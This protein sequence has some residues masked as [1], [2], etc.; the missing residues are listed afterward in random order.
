MESR[1]TR[2]N[3]RDTNRF[4]HILHT[5]SGGFLGVSGRHEDGTP[6][7]QEVQEPDPKNPDLTVVDP[8]DNEYPW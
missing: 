8:D 1:S 7:I 3:V 2:C 5:V 4:G 6:V